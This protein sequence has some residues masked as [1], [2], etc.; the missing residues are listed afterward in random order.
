MPAD[1][2]LASAQARAV[3][4]Q[5]DT[6]RILRE[7][8]T[9]YSS[10]LNAAW[11]SSEMKPINHIIEDLQCQLDGLAVR[12][13]VLQTTLQNGVLQLTELDSL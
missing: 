13:D 1:I 4:E 3:G 8:L 2:V 7:E 6:I 5:A 10:K 11:V 12:L 9:V